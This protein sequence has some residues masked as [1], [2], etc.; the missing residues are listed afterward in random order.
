MTSTSKYEMEAMEKLANLT[1][2]FYA[3]LS[4]V[5][6]QKWKF[7]KSMLAECLN[8]LCFIN[9]CPA[10]ISAAYKTFIQQSLG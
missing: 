9:Y 1:H 7:S 10:H 5:S 3:N 4:S 8:F 6:A 2:I